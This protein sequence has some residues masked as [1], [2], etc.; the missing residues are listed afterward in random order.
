MDLVWRGAISGGV[1][2]GYFNRPREIVASTI[3]IAAYWSAS[4][5]MSGSSGP[6]L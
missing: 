2:P 6:L 5:A 4:Y 3:T 1:S